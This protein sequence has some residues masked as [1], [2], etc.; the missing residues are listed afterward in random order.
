MRSA[1]I[2]ARRVRLPGWAVVAVIAGCAVG[3]DYHR[4]ETPVDT[5]FANAGEPGF[6]AERC[7]RALL[8]RVSR[9]PCSTAW[10]RTR[11]RTTRT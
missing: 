5:H 8:D 1:A 2:G 10:S 6:A 3:P 4:P 9:I 7:G 11:W